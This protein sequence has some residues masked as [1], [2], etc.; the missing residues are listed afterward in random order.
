[1]FRSFIRTIHDSQLSKQ[2]FFKQPQSTSLGVSLKMFFRFCLRCHSIYKKNS[3]S[4]VKV[5]KKH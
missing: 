4:K 5:N 1:M 2:G 3:I